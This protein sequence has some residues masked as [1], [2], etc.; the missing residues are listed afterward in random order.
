[1]TGAFTVISLPP[2]QKVNV[3]KFLLE[4]FN[5]YQS[6][7]INLW[8]IFSE[9]LWQHFLTTFFIWLFGLFIWGAPFILLIVGIRGFSFGFT[10][11]FMVENYRF[12]GFLFSMVCIIPQSMIYVPC[13]I[14]MG[15]IALIFSTTAFEKKGI[16]YKR[17]G[18][19]DKVSAYTSKLIIIFLIL[20]V[21]MLFETFVAPFLFPLFIWIFR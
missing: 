15:I 4:F 19:R 6:K 20:Q 7:P 18:N 1:M 14:G 5:S 12:G 9:S 17:I 10:I 21:G 3:G 11:G 13:Y 2:Q 16:Y 8:A